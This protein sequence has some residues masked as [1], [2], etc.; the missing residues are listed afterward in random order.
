VVAAAGSFRADALDGLVVVGELGLDGSVRPVRGVLAVAALARRLG[1]RGVVVPRTCAA[2]A[3]L[4]DG[5]A[6]YPVSH[7]GDVLRAMEGSEPLVPWERPPARAAPAVAGVD[8]SEVRGQAQARRAVEIAVAGGHSLLLYGP[9]GLGKTML[10]SRVPTILPP[11]NEDEA[12]EVTCIYSAAGQL[13][14]EGLVTRRP[15]RAPHHGISTSAL[16]GGGTV[17]RPGEISLAHRGVL[18]LDELPEFP[19]AA[20][21]ALRQPLE[22]RVVRVSRVSGSVTMPASFL[23][24]AAANPCPCGWHGSKERT[25]TCA[26]GAIER[27]RARVSGPILDRIDL[28][29]RVRNVPVAELLGAED[30]EP[31][32]AIR[33]RVQEARARQAARLEAR[34]ATVNGEMDAGT[35]RATCRLTPPPSERW[36]SCTPPA[37]GSPRAASI[38]SCAPRAPSPTSTATTSS[39]R[40]PCSRPLRSA[41]STP[42]RWP[43]SCRCHPHGRRGREGGY[44]RRRTRPG[45]G[46]AS[47]QVAAGHAAGHGTPVAER[48]AH[49]HEARGV[50]AQ[51]VP[52]HADAQRVL[53]LVRE[54]ARGAPARV[55]APAV[56]HGA[57]LGAQPDSRW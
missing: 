1:R 19:R 56:G 12:I 46:T 7:L 54:A 15:F 9:P 24:V 53:D 41:A 37:P 26:P 6:V 27:Y 20:I 4:I 45:A 51:P 57:A 44:C 38:A 52:I 42:S 14:P 40:M 35:Q 16:V 49:G 31:S 23:L 39:T 30:G 5:I 50:P 32:S 55:R 13:P 28:Q 48:S 22:E 33:A 29:V 36:R 21:E 10:A 3:G 34:G 18:F 47:S 17:P 43:R 11:M 8:F 25:C 2:E